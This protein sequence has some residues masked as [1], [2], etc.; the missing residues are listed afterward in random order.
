MGNKHTFYKHPLV[1]TVPVRDFEVG[2]PAFWGN[3]L[4][5]SSLVN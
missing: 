4:P 2:T 1:I 5:P 3:I